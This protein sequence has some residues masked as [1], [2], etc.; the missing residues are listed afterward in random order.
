[1]KRI[2]RFL[3]LLL[4]LPAV[5][6]GQK[7]LNEVGAVYGAIRSMTPEAYKEA[8]DKY[9]IR[10][11][12]AWTGNLTGGTEEQYDAWITRFN[13]AMKGSGL[14]L[15][16]V[17]LPFTRKSP[18]DLSDNRPEWREATLKNWIEILDRATRLGKFRVVVMHPSSEAQISDGERPQRLENLR[19][20]L[21]RFI[22]LVKERYGA[23]VAV[24]D[25]PRGCLG[26]SSAD[27]DWLAANVPG[28][29]I[30]YDTNHLLGEESHA[31]AAR[32]APYIVNIHVSDYDGV[33]ERHWMP[34]RGIVEWPKVIDILTR[35]GYDGP[36]MY[37]VTPHNDPRG[38]AEYMRQ[39]TDSLFNC[40]TLYKKQQGNKH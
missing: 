23:V 10:W 22:P 14:K 27:F 39:T 38:S 5:A 8:H 35:S 33:D 18:N 40:Y 37:E 1:M 19:E 24:E 6:S 29:K 16:S 3:P 31:F 12:E 26:N 25:L 21:L 4:L 2:L 15:W 17:H 7:R 32:F 28:F 13:T 34:G 20:M 9:G 11:I 30:C 36:F